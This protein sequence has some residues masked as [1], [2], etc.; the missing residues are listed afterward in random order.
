MKLKRKTYTVVLLKAGIQSKQI[1]KHDVWSPPVGLC[2]S[3]T[4][5]FCEIGQLRLPEL[6]R[7]ILTFSNYWKSVQI[8]EK[9]KVLKCFL[10]LHELQLYQRL[11][12]LAVFTI[13]VET[14]WVVAEQHMSRRS[15]SNTGFIHTVLYC[16]PLVTT[17][18]KS[19]LIMGFNTKLLVALNLH[20]LKV[21]I[22]QCKQS[23]KSH[24]VDY[25]SSKY[26]HS[27]DMVWWYVAHHSSCTIVT[28]TK[29]Q[30]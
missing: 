30:F 25:F 6:C 26:F 23:L 7:L 20:D 19:P 3:Y 2:P 21:L 27:I 8:S 5:I 13:P 10:A 22:K 16:S 1:L 4:V 29:L 28:I 14:A 15:V 11:T 18:L 12:W 17:I 24:R 9:Q